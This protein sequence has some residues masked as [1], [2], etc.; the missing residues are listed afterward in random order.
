MHSI[1][2]F[3]CFHSILLKKSEH[4]TPLLKIPQWPKIPNPYKV[5]KILSG[6]I[7]C[8]PPLDHS[9]S[10]TPAFSLSLRQ[11][12]HPLPAQEFCTCC[13]LCMEHFSCKILV[14]CSLC[15]STASP[16]YHFLSK[17]FPA[18]LSN[19]AILVL[20]P[21]ILYPLSLFCF[22]LLRTHHLLK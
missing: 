21:D 2:T 12:R 20:I 11:S 15:F 19:I 10:A 7:L 3:T 17:A 1:F 4:L 16:T 14:V 22:F 6:L 9:A 13:Y 8:D 5:D 18:T